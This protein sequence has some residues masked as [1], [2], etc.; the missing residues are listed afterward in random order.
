MLKALVVLIGLITQ[1]KTGQ[2]DFCYSAN[3]KPYLYMGTKTAYDY[4]HGNIGHTRIT[5][6]D[7]VQIWVLARHGTRY[8]G[9]CTIKDMSNLSSFRDKIL[10]NHYVHKIA[11]LCEKDL[12]NLKNWNLYPGLKVEDAKLLTMKGKE[13]E[14]Y[15]ARRLKFNFPELLLANTSDVTVK[16][17]RFRTTATSRTRTSMEAFMEGLFGSGTAVSNEELPLHEDILLRPYKLCE[18]WSK[19]N[20]TYENHEGNEFLDG[21]EMGNLI[22]NVSQ[23]LGFSYVLPRDT[24]I[25]MWDTCRFE[26]AWNIN[27]SSPWC[28]VFSTDELLVME[29]KDDLFYYYEFGYGREINKRL[30]CPL[31]KDLFSHFSKLQMSMQNDEPKGIFYFA[32]SATLQTFLAAMEIARDSKPLKASNYNEQENRKWRTSLITPFASNFVAVYHKCKSPSSDRVA[33]Y[34]AEK[35]LTYE[36]CNEGIC[37][38]NHLQKKLGSFAFNCTMDFCQD[39]YF[40]GSFTSKSAISLVLLLLLCK[41]ISCQCFLS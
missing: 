5:D 17:Y 16:N 19:T 7:P 38:W 41:W 8:P 32:H 26:Q 31:V 30:G 33:F 23:R 37:D 20:M 40:S 11:R 36:G 1:I 27:K 29:Y 28:S 15:F 21:P 35:P 22:R 18:T 25:L 6:C 24:V 13:D 9:A 10:E 4:V 3:T 12:N 39:S 34:L 14:E 2:V